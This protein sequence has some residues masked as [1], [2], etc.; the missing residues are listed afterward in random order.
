MELKMKEV[1]EKHDTYSICKERVLEFDIPRVGTF[2]KVPFEEFKK[3]MIEYL[4]SVVEGKEEL[5]QNIYDTIKLP[6]RNHSKSATYKFF[7]PFAA[8]PKSGSGIVIPTGIKCKVEPG[9]LL[10]I[11]PPKVRGFKYGIEIYNTI[12]ILDSTSED[13]HIILK[14][15]AKENSTDIIDKGTVFC[16]GIFLPYGLA[17]NDDN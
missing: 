14:I 4:G 12:N 8:M 9:W 15:T 17:T 6:E 3:D 16:Q 10:Q 13:N 1:I 5:I 7:I 2:E 11:F